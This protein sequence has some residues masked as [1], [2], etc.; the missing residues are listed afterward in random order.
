MNSKGQATIYGLIFLIVIVI[1][2]TSFLPIFQTL[3]NNARTSNA[4]NCASNIN[5]CSVTS[6][7]PC[8]NSSLMTETTSCLILDMFLPLLIL[9]V[10]VGGA[11]AVIQQKSAG[12]PF[13]QQ[14]YGGYQ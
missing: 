1:L 9:V 13:G 4:L 7:I 10:L 8:Y 12:S 6:E 14:Q 11:F 2:I 3:L 5:V